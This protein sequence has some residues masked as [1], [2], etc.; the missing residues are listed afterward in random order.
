[1]VTLLH[2]IVGKGHF[3]PIHEAK[4]AAKFISQ[5]FYSIG[6]AEFK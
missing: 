1:L 6:K 5:I 3:E 4:N 2:N